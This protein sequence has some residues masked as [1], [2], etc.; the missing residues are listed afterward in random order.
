MV[1]DRAFWADKRVLL[2]GHTGFKGAWMSLW[3]QRLGAQCVG[4]SL[5][6]A[7]DSM[8]QALSPWSSLTSVSVDVCDAPALTVAV[9]E[10][11]P[12]IVIHM[13]AQAIVN[14]GYRDPQSTMSTNVMGTANLLDSLREE[15]D[16]VAILVVTSDKCY[17]NDNTGIP[18]KESDPLGGADP[19]SA[20]KAC[21]EIVTSSWAH[22][23]FEPTTAVATARA[24]NVIGG[25]D[26][27]VNRLIPDI[28]RARRSG[29]PLKL[30]YPNATR[31]WQ[32]VLEPLSG[33][34]SYIEALVKHPH[35]IPRA[36]NFAAP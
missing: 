33:Y 16:L 17:R 9:R 20:S 2:T 6:P 19:Y 18:F 27:S 13:A 35:T 14:E 30:R 8:Y 23:F 34:L 29:S 12:Q 1:I 3:M 36:L 25:G 21:Q 22:S 10:A 4:L 31:P 26:F 5:A 24:G 28:V 15:S 7:P 32:H 11:R